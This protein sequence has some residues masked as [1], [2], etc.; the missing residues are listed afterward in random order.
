MPDLEPHWIEN[1]G[2]VALTGGSSHFEHY[3]SHLDR[4]FDVFSYQYVPRQFAVII[5]DITERKRLEEERARLALQ[6]QQAQ[7]MESI[8]R[9]AGGVAHDFNNMLGVILGHAELALQQTDSMQPIQDD[10]TEILKAANRS[11]DLTRQL[12]AFARRQTVTPRVLDL[13]QTIAGMLNMLKRMIGEN[14]LLEWQPAENLWPIRIDPSQIDQILANLCVNS[15]DAISDVGKITIETGNCT[16]NEGFCSA[17]PWFVP[18]EYVQLAVRDDGCGMDKDTLANIFEPFFT[19]KG[20]GKGTGLGL[21]TVYG[22]VKQNNGHILADSEPGQGTTLTIYL[23]RYA[24]E[25][26]QAPKEETAKPAM[27]GQETILLVEDEP[28]LLQMVTKALKKK[29]YKV[30]AASTPREALRLATEHGS[31][32]HLL[33]TD[34]VMPEMSG[35]DLAEHLLSINPQLKRLFVSGYTADVISHNGVLDEGT[36]FIQKP[37]S[38]Q[39]LAVKVH[40][41]LKA[42]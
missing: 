19:T 35:Q 6:F 14:I 40:E 26:K 12:L 24:G 3:N 36:H 31:E 37:F 23:P 22:I 1:Y 5:R 41:V 17:H 38:I 27:D 4:W 13:N 34:V 7:K 20:V 30:L 32:I 28:A 39:D 11:A 42:E 16:P 15:R 33:M 18:G 25:A 29:G 9:L 2:R 10:L 21:S 8:G